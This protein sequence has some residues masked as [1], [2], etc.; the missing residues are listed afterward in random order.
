MEYIHKI[1]LTTIIKTDNKIV[2]RSI[3]EQVIKC[4]IILLL[5]FSGTYIRSFASLLIVY[6]NMMNI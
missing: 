2:Y 4:T 6:Y 5:H 3:E 1:M